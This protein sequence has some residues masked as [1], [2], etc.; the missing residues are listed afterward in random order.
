MAHDVT[1]MIATVKAE[2]HWPDEDVAILRHLVRALRHFRHHRFY[3]S[4]KAGTLVTVAD[5]SAYVRGS[6]ADDVPADLLE[7]DSIRCEEGSG[8][9][10][11]EK[12]S[13]EQMR[14]AQ[15]GSTTG[16]NSPQ[17]YSWH[18]ETLYLWP[19][20]GSV[21]TLNIDYL[22]DATRDT[23]TGG[24]IVTD[25]SGVA[26]MTNEFFT[27]GEELLCSRILYSLAL[28]RAEDAKAALTAK[29]A[30]LEALNSLQNESVIRKVG[31]SFQSDGY[32]G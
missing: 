26:T 2:S 5:Q 20:P 3:F 18:A 11:L 17:I 29:T 27:R 19:T 31:S 16:M 22:F 28:G 21:W 9:T 8:E 14:L 13:I 6:G 23:A 10:I 25:A 12:V 32:F 30:Y 4:E 1:E 24:E 7:I 15:A